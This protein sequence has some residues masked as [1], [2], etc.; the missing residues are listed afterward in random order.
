MI[1]LRKRL[2]A[3]AGL[4]GGA[5]ILAGTGH[6]RPSPRSAPLI[7][8]PRAQLAKRRASLLLRPICTRRVPHVSGNYRAFLARDA[9]RTQLSRL[10]VFDLEYFGSPLHPPNGAHITIAAGAVS[11]LTSFADP[12]SASPVVALTG[13]VR[14]RARSQPISFGPRTW[15]GQSGILY[16]APEYPSGG[17]LGDHLVFQWRRSGLMYVISLHSWAPLLETAAVKSSEVV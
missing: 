12:T 14:K 17:Q 2:L 15:N 13:A 11:R 9:E 1:L 16:L 4:V 5:A 7:S 6:S 8:L 3:L 10:H